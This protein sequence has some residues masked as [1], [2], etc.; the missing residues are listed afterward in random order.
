MKLKQQ[1]LLDF[2]AD[3]AELRYWVM[4]CFVAASIIIGYASNHAP[5]F[6]KVVV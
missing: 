5:V 4:V 1:L 3:R 2:K 6:F